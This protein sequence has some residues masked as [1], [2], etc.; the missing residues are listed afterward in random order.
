MTLSSVICQ[1][2]CLGK[3]LSR[4]FNSARNF[5]RV[6][7]LIPDQKSSVV[8]EKGSDMHRSVFVMVNSR[9]ASI[10]SRRRG[11]SGNP[12]VVLRLLASNLVGEVLHLPFTSTCL[13]TL[14]L[15]ICKH[16][17]A[18]MTS[19]ALTGKS[20]TPMRKASSSSAH[21]PRSRWPI[22]GMAVSRDVHSSNKAV[23]F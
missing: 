7:C 10:L 9:R 18:G 20:P 17:F 14:F 1:S 5:L 19:A 15:S 3:Q 22:C 13:F 6:I 8:Q 11:L 21:L 12:R 2:T 16:Y 23:A 4:S